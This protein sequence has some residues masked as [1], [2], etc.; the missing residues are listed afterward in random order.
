MGTIALYEDVESPVQSGSVWFAYYDKA[1]DTLT[2]GEMSL[3]RE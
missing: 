3:H 2:L 1:A